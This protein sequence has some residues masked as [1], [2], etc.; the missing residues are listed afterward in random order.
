MA[1]GWGKEPNNLSSVERPAGASRTL[2]RRTSSRERCQSSANLLT[3]VQRRI[4]TVFTAH[5][6]VR[7][8]AR[9]RDL[10]L[11]AM[12]AP[13]V[14]EV[15]RLIADGILMAQLDGDALEDF[16]HLGGRFREESL[17]A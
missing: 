8:P 1:R 15:R 12:P 7:Q 17:A 13:V 10:D 6:Q 3:R 14:R 2:F 4:I 9:R 5:E 11:D 16:V